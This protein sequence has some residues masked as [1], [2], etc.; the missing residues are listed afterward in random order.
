MTQGEYEK[1][2]SYS[3]TTVG[4]NKMNDLLLYLSLW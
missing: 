4:F 3:L 1:I 2:E